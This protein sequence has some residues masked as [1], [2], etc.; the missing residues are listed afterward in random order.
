MIVAV[1]VLHCNTSMVVA[2]VSAAAAAVVLTVDIMHITVLLSQQ[3]KLKSK[4][5]ELF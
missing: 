1:D 4:L 3:S 5:M 2:I